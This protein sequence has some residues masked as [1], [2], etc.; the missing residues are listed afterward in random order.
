[1]KQVIKIDEDVIDLVEK[2][3][4]DFLSKKKIIEYILIND[5]NINNDLWNIYEKNYEEAFISFELTK[6]NF[7]K[8]LTAFL[9]KDILNWEIINFSEGLVEVDIK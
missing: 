4:Y 3:Y 2:Y 1:M 6:E 9:K 8:Y 7:S 5:I